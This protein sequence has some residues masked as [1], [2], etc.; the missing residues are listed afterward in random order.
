MK[1]AL[2]V[3]VVLAVI[4]V[5]AWAVPSGYMYYKPGTP[6]IMYVQYQKQ[7]ADQESSGVSAF[8][9]GDSGDTMTIVDD[10]QKGEDIL[11]EE[12]AVE[13][14]TEEKED[15]SV[16]VAQGYNSE[17]I[18]VAYPAEDSVD[19]YD[20]EAKVEPSR[21]YLPPSN[22]YLP[23]AVLNEVPNEDLSFTKI[24]EEDEVAP[25]A[26]AESKITVDG[27]VVAEEVKAEE[28]VKTV[29]ENVAAE[30]EVKTV[31][32][33]PTVE[34]TREPK[35]IVE[36]EVATADEVKTV[37]EDQVVVEDTKTVVENEELPVDDAKAVADESVLVVEEPT[38]VVQDLPEPI[39]V[40]PVVPVV[41]VAPVTPTKRTRIFPA[42]R[43]NFVPQR[44]KVYV[45]LEQEDEQEYVPIG[46]RQVIKPKKEVVE[47]EEQQPFP[48]GGTFFPINFGGTSGGAIAIANS[49]STSKGGSSKSQAVAYGSGNEA[50]RAR[51][52][53]KSTQAD[54]DC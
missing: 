44:R 31:Y 17:S 43:P 51:K 26:I 47:E 53:V 1:C 12:R 25:V 27:E 23:P 6:G 3:V 14:E 46:N 54:C 33:V 13:V 50:F 30:E 41:P 52:P 32:G 48:L 5:G 19:D 10:V 42:K 24:A 18:A 45:Q 9:A 4:A 35:N 36:E 37:E 38:P 28:E 34:E 40:I 2:S 16:S 20:G 49:F 29:E 22:E 8:V 11:S 39:P 7:G 21:D 15:Q